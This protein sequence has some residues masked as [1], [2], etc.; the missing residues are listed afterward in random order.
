MRKLAVIGQI[1]ELNDI[2]GA[3]RIKQAI[4][5]CGDAGVWAGIVGLDLKVCNKV[6]VF[7]QDA[8]LP[9]NDRWAFMESHKW[10]VKMCRF[11]KVASECLIISGCPDM[12]V[13]TDLTEA[14]GVIKYEKPIPADMAG[15]VDG[16][17]PSFI[18]RT[19][20]ENFQSAPELVAKM[21]DSDWYATEK[22]D[23]TS[24]TIFIDDETKALKVCSRNWP[25]K[26]SENVYWKAV[27]KY[28]LDTNFNEKGVALQF[29]VVGPGIQ[30]NPMGLDDIE[31]RLFSAYDFYEHFYMSHR[32]LEEISKK[33]KIPLAKIIFRGYDSLTR[34]EL[35]KLA[36]IKYDGSR[37]D[38]EGIVIRDYRNTWSFKVINLNYKD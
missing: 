27:R 23:G 24:C 34:E 15:V 4:V 16:V 32:I 8:L 3:D 5:D 36:E 21:K 38:G 25:L 9:P 29:E 22:A 14:L 10:R 19:D 28:N 2:A 30:K 11:K 17:W 12:P 13:G 7:L 31:I 37:K 20:E 18:P 6:T 1:I 26:E 33:Y 35:L